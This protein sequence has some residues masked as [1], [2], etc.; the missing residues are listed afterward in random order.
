MGGIHESMTY[1]DYIDP[2]FEYSEQSNLCV[3]VA[4]LVFRRWVGLRPGFFR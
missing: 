4:L 2:N 3:K 1:T